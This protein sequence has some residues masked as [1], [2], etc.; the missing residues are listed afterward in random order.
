MKTFLVISVLVVVV[1][2]GGAIFLLSTM[3]GGSNILGP[4]GDFFPI[5]GQEDIPTSENVPG[6]GTD[7]V[8]SPLGNDSEGWSV[9]LPY[10]K[11]TDREIV[12]YTIISNSKGEKLRYLERGTGHIYDYALPSR[13]ESKVSNKTITRVQEVLWG[14]GGESFIVRQ[15]P[16]T[17]GIVKN[18]SFAFEV[19]D[20]VRDNTAGPLI[21]M[22]TLGVGDTGPDV[23]SLQRILN[24]SE[25]TQIASSGQG[26]PG[27][28]TM[29]YGSLTASAVKKFQAL[30]TTPA[31]PTG[32]LDEET[33]AQ[34]NEVAKNEYD[35]GFG[36][37]G[38]VEGETPL[39]ALELPSIQEITLSPR[40]NQIFYI[41]REN[42]SAVGRTADLKNKGVRRVYQSPFG[43]WS[44]SWLQEN[45]VALTTKP[46][47]SVLGYLYFLNISSGLLTPILKDILGLTALVD[48]GSLNLIYSEKAKIGNGLFMYFFNR[49]NRTTS[50]LPIQTLP[51][52]CVWSK[53]TAGLI[54]CG[55]PNTLPGGEYPDSWY[56]G[57]IRFSDSIWGVRTQESEHQLIWNPKEETLSQDI[58]LMVPLLNSDETT[59]FFMNKRDASLWSLD[60]DK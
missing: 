13:E 12:G 38:E 33:R 27:A 8:D 10:R 16:D 30:H 45:T 26:S 22:S 60:L 1:V 14:T 46:S 44:V 17:R 36:S 29:Y 35:R 41:A 28:E 6:D 40:G 4:L 53:K 50:I 58:D 24:M 23:L 18:I 56:R 21:I 55:V 5:S 15:S 37:S 49:A 42:D 11:I 51:E 19:E 47:E 43:E 48:P 54:Y 7:E 39:E 25:S 20:G 3:G 31:E 57:E 32:V 2:L 59:L 34:L 9:S 52:K